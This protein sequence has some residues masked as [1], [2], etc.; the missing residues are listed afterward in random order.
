MAGTRRRTWV[1]GL[2]ALGAAAVVVAA[3]VFQHAQLADASADDKLVA[4]ASGDDLPRRTAAVAAVGKLGLGDR[5]DW[6]KSY[7]YDLEQGELCAHRKPV[8]AKLRALG[9]PAAIPALEQAL[10]RLGTVGKWKGKNVNACLVDDA[11]AAITY[12]QGLRT[13]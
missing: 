11:K 3:L 6:G 13:K 9:D 12:L 10:V 7:R 8:V 4:W 5:V 2:A 1:A